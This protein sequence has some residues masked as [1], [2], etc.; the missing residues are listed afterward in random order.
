MK[1]SI[2]AEQKAFKRARA[3]LAGVPDE[4][5][6]VF[7]RSFNRAAEQGRTVAIQSVTSVYTIKRKDVKKTFK[8]YRADKNNLE[9]N[10]ESRGSDLDLGHFR[11]SPRHDTTGNKRKPIRV[12]IKKGNKVILERAFI[13]GQKAGRPRVFYRVSDAR[14]PVKFGVTSSVPVMLNNEKVVKEVSEK[15]REATLRRLD[16]E[17]KRVLDKVG[18]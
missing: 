8:L 16:H 14:Y 17:T 2:D 6:K 13:H 9:A 4:L 10:L 12:E 1:V 7:A 18:G 3:L 15:M 5:P 11:V